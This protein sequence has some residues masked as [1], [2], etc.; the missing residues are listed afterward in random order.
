MSV[1]K[2]KLSIIGCRFGAIVSCPLRKRRY[3]HYRHYRLQ[4]AG[5]LR[6]SLTDIRT[7]T[8]HPRKKGTST[9]TNTH[10]TP[11]MSFL[12]HFGCFSCFAPMSRLKT[13]SN[14]CFATS[15]FFW[16]F[17]SLHLL[18]GVGRRGRDFVDA[19]AILVTSF[20]HRVIFGRN[21]A[22]FSLPQKPENTTRLD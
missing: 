18:P 8:G 11:R 14:P 15:F 17:F 6:P 9:T 7:L 4:A 1:Q 2:A 20:G 19:L 21:H 10:D 22:P 5:L 16:S 13:F 3:M 12:R